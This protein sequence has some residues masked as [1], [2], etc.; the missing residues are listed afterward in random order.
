MSGPSESRLLVLDIGNTTITAGAFLGESLAGPWRVSTRR[1]RSA[2]EYG[3]L[4]HG[5][6]RAAGLDPA[7]VGA[8]IVSCVVPPVVATVTEMAQRYFGTEPLFVE[9]GVK[10]GIAI[11]TE[12]PQEVG[13]D[14]IVNAVSAFARHGGPAIVVD[15]GTATT[16]DAV[17]ARGEYLGGVIAP[18]IGIAAEAL[19][20]RAAKLPRVDIRRPRQVIGRNTVAS[21]QSGLLLGYAALVDGIVRRMAAELAP[22]AGEGVV[23]LATGGHAATLAG[24]CQTIQQVEPDLT[25]DGLRRIWERNVPGRPRC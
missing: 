23:V 21:I 7:G 13:A 1:E 20:T 6:L 4:L 11:L 12:N 19:F 10:T 22:P 25:L 17:S 3:I 5:L 14:R 15:F 16:F 9:P 24:E 2:D 18:G 8:V